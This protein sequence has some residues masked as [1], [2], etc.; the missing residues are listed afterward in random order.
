MILLG[1]FLLGNP[2]L[3][4]WI[5]YPVLL[6]Y[7]VMV[8]GTPSVVRAC[9][10]A[11]FP[12][13]A[14][15]VGG[16]DD[17]PTSLSAA[18]L[19]DFHVDWLYPENGSYLTCQIDADR[20]GSI[21]SASEA[22]PTAV[23]L[24]S[25]DYLGNITDVAEISSV[26][27][28]HGVILAVDN[29]HGAYLKLLSPSRHPIDLGADICCD[30]A[31][32]TLPVLTGGAYLHISKDAPSIFADGA[33]SALSLFGSTSPSYLILESL[34]LANKYIAE[35][36]AEKL[37]EFVR[38]LDTFKARLYDMGFALIGNEPLKLTIS[39]R[40]VGYTGD[41]LAFEIAKRGGICEFSDPDFT[42]MML[43]P[44][45]GEDGLQRIESILSDIKVCDPLKNEKL[46]LPRPK[47]IISPQKALFSEIEEISVDDCEGRIQAE[48]SVSCP[49]A[50]P[51]V[52]CGEEIDKASVNMLKY[53]GI[54]K[55]RVVK[56]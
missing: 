51:I 45:L 41:G 9:I 4:A 38:Q 2:Y 50:V 36:Y 44:E 33:R 14:P 1:S 29:A 10:M 43:T 34:D 12:L 39:A 20:L 18:A 49:P 21:L 46:E 35:G 47:S 23:Y 37:S 53:Y 26:C 42:V 56:K 27:R 15:V 52:V 3:K 11:G 16:E 24:T 40:D 17:P 48:A 32:K 19:L 6:F 5:G 28:A 25:P 30:S 22:K 54:K 55:C 13:M 7:M 8:G 31:H